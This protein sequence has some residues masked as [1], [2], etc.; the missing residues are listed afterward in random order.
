MEL[1]TDSIA[2]AI[3]GLSLLTLFAM[4]V[5]TSRVVVTVPGYEAACVVGSI[6][7]VAGLLLPIFKGRFATVCKFVCSI[8]LA[9]QVTFISMVCLGAVSEGDE[10]EWSGL[11]VD[12]Y[13]LG[14]RKNGSKA[15]L[16]VTIDGHKAFIHSVDVPVFA[17]KEQYGPELQDSIKVDVTAQQV[18]PHFYVKPRATV[19]APVQ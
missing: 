5:A 1:S 7:L 10:K 17:L 4:R 19:T 8:A 12:S 11:K 6:C 13:T 18:V 3:S 16:T 2:I 14:N 9:I 15:Y